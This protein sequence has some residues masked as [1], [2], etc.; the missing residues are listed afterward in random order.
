M[1]CVVCRARIEEDRWVKIANARRKSLNGAYHVNCW[2]A[3]WE[4]RVRTDDEY[5]FWSVKTTEEKVG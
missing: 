2:F 5:Q 1:T 3:T 4:E